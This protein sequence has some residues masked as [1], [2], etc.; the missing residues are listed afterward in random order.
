MDSSVD[1]FAKSMSAATAPDTN[2]HSTSIPAATPRSHR[3][4]IPP[5]PSSVNEM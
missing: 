4:S 5:P 1:F 3:F 2:A